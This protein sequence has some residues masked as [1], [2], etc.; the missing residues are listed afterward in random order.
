MGPQT[1][2][3]FHAN[4]TVRPTQEHLAEFAKFENFL[5]VFSIDDIEEQFEILRWPAKW[6]EVVEN[7]LWLKENSPNNVKFAFNVVIS[8]LN[9]S[10][11]HRVEQ[12]MKHNVPTNKVGVDTI[13]YTNETNG[14]LNRKD[15]LDSRDPVAFLDELDQKRNTDWRK[16]FPLVKL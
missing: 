8:K 6:N 14:L 16:V 10:T 3:H 15:P 12:W 7:I 13:F 5:L 1:E 2:I 11:Y 4:G 9:E